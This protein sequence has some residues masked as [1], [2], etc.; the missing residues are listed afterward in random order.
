MKCPLFPIKPLFSNCV[1][2]S[3][4]GLLAF[5]QLCF[6][7]VSNGQLLPQTTELLA[8]IKDSIFIQ[9]ITFFFKQSEG[10]RGVGFSGS[11]EPTWR[12]MEQP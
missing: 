1:H 8:K 6:V 3:L 4:H 7:A 5:Q 9:S 12:Q 11:M 10:C 2:S